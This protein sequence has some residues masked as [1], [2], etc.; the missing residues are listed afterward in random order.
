MK[1]E[2]RIDKLALFTRVR[3]EVFYRYPDIPGYKLDKTFDPNK[4]N[5]WDKQDPEALKYK[6]VARFVN[7][8]TGNVLLICNHRKP[9]KK[10][11]YVS[12]LYVIFYCSYDS[13]LSCD[14]VRLVVAY[15][16]HNHRVRLRV[17]MVHLAIDI[18]SKT[19]KR[20]FKK[21][22]RSFKPGRKRG[23]YRP[24]SKVTRQ[25]L[26]SYKTT[27]YFGAPGVD[28]RL[29]IYDKTK[30]LRRRHN[31]I[32]DDYVCR[33]EAQFRPP[34]LKGF[35]QTVN[36]LAS[37]D[38]TSICQ[39]HFSFHRPTRKLKAMFDDADLSWRKPIWELRDIAEK[40]FGIRP[41]N[42]YRDYLMKH[43]TLSGKVRKALK[44]YRWC[45]NHHKHQNQP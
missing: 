20:L 2:A 1:V 38:W 11:G 41:S 15:F 34:E 29:V 5:K 4:R 12:P 32:I 35:V 42:F 8:K 30:E 37:Y 31:V 17:S 19:D 22:V 18:I 21:V 45:P 39:R 27:V 23:P 43:P 10:A 24:K 13:P 25:Q 36:D 7:E 6:K 3:G 9:T 16:W 14:E 26:K 44:R 28:N 33:V 40:Q